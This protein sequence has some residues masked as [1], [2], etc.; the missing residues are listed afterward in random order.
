[1]STDPFRR[2]SSRCGDESALLPLAMTD[3]STGLE[4]K[5]TELLGAV[6]QRLLPWE[7]GERDLLGELLAAGGLLP[8]PAVELR[9]DEVA[10]VL[11]ETSS[12]RA[13]RTDLL[14][15]LPR[16][17][18]AD[19][20]VLELKAQ[21][22]K[23]DVQQLIRYRDHPDRSGRRV[24]VA[25]LTPDL[26]APEHVTR[27]GFAWIGLLG[28]ADLLERLAVPGRA[29]FRQRDAAATFAR[30]ARYQWVPG[31][32]VVVADEYVHDPVHRALHVVPLKAQGHAHLVHCSHVALVSRDH[33]GRHLEPGLHRINATAT[34]LLPDLASD[35]TFGPAAKRLLEYV[36]RGADS[37]LSPVTPVLL[38][39][40]EDDARLLAGG[41]A[42]LLPAGVVA[43]GRVSWLDEVPPGGY[44]DVGEALAALG[45]PR[46]PDAADASRD[47]GATAPI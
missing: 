14:L 1:M 9:P 3:R 22:R 32:P 46:E 6:L 28:L 25:S 12:D 19:E 34:G 47:D 11:E 39:Q 30:W 29:S 42:G 36:T 5:T 10:F 21:V 33:Q 17:A 23:A 8:G 41:T 16:H 44:R 35:P 45:D 37:Y 26:L 20:I 2:P 15:R 13:H 24:L 18:P 4:N 31:V 43:D 7:P 40:L 38:L 27:A